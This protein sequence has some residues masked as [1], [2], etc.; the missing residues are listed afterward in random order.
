MKIQLNQ[1]NTGTFFL[2]FIVLAIF[3]ASCKSEDDSTPKVVVPDTLTVTTFNKSHHFFAGWSAEDNL[4]TI[5]Q[6]FE[7]PESLDDYDKIFMEIQ[8]ECPGNGCDP[9]DRAAFIEMITEENGQEKIYEIGRYITPYKIGCN[10]TIDVSDYRNLLQG[11]VSLKSHIDTWTNPGWSL[12]V[13]F[14]FIE[15]E[16]E[17]SNIQVENLWYT[18]GVAYGVPEKPIPYPDGNVDIHSNAQKVKVKI[19]TTG[20]SF[21]NTGNAA[22][23]F[24][25]DHQ[26]MINNEAKFTHHLWRSDCAQNPCSPQFGTWKFARAGWCPGADVIPEEFDITNNISPGETINLK[27]QLMD[28]TNECRRDNPNCVTGVNCSDCENPPGE[29]FYRISVQVISYI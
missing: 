15:G 6:D 7:F 19:V 9:W 29:P 10:W 21:G 2:S 1:V 27:Y 13:N 22:E 25:A 4:R 14:K 8:L 28:Y 26:L 18:Q 20:H 16:P 17:Y 24:P 12:T 5:Q 23:F 11:T 3:I